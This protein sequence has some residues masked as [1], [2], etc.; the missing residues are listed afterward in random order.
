MMCKSLDK[1]QLQGGLSLIND[2]YLP[3]MSEIY[4]SEVS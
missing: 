4:G 3:E 1:N 2:F